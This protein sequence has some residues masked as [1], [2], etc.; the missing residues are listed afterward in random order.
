MK[1]D[2]YYKQLI[3]YKDNGQKLT[4]KINSNNQEQ[5]Q[6]KGSKLYAC[7]RLTYASD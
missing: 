4:I 1:Y 3:L 2:P 5:D 6:N 7:V